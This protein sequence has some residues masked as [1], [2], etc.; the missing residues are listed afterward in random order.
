MPRTLWWYVPKIS[1][2][3]SERLLLL[4]SNNRGTFLIRESETTK[5]VISPSGEAASLG[6]IPAPSTHHL[7]LSASRITRLPHLPTP[8]APSLPARLPTRTSLGLE[9]LRALC[10]SMASFLSMPI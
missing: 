2:K 10:L 8:A 6:D 7:V 1:R 9:T 4:N 5:A 3:D